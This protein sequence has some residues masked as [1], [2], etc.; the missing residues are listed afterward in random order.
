MN[1]C[2]ANSTC[3]SCKKR[4][5]KSLKEII[6]CYPCEHY[7]HR[8]C[9]DN[10][11]S[12][13]CFI[14]SCDNSLISYKSKCDFNLNDQH[15]INLTSLE[16]TPYIPSYYDIFRAVFYRVPLLS[17]YLFRFL[18]AKK[19]YFALQK[20]LTDVSLT[21]N[22]N[23]KLKGDEYI[24][25][26]KKVYIAN[27]SSFLDALIIPQF[28]ITGAVAS[29]SQANNYFGKLMKECSHV[30]FVERGKINNS[31]EKI[32]SHI[33]KYGSLLF[34]PEGLFSH[35]KTLTQ[36]RTGAFA[37]KFNVQPILLLYEQNV[38]SLSMFNILC[39]P[40]TD[41]VLKILPEEKRGVDE[42]VYNFTERIRKN[43]AIE[44]NLLLSNVSSRD[45]VD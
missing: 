45:I 34:C 3:P 7:Y 13:K 18:I 39:N 22:I 24:D 15:S 6:V 26:K 21:L 14:D 35:I 11:I 12:C 36:F 31:V 25:D 8:E 2:Q 37:T 16:R 19:S 10:N 32:Q 9:F 27:H 17:Y 30:Y 43:M 28:I 40:K 5:N 1:N 42:S 23:V 20:T 4:F 41:L 33:E 29:I 38:S 44:G